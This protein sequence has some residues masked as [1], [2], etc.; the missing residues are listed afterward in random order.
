MERDCPGNPY[1]SVAD[2]D[3]KKRA[4]QK[5]S[6]GKQEKAGCV[7]VMG[8]TCPSTALVTRD[9]CLCGACGAEPAEVPPALLGF[10]QKELGPVSEGLD[11]DSGSPVSG[12][13]V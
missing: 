12:L 7:A 5:D 4:Q 10:T 1:N 8:E 3:G 9:A 13:S 2:V 11:L 6:C